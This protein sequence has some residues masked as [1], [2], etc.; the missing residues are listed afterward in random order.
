MNKRLVK[1]NLITSIILQFAT[2][3]SG[4][5]TPKVLLKAFGS[6]TNGLVSSI[7]QFIN[8]ITLLEGGVTSVAIASLYKPIN[9]ND[10]HEISKKI[11]AISHYFRTLSILSALFTIIVGLIYPLLVKTDF[12]NLYIFLLTCVLGGHLLIQYSLSITYKI[13]LRA[14]QKVYY[15][16]LT[17]LIIVVINLAVVIVTVNYFKDILIVKMASLATYLIQPLMYTTYVKRHY[18]IPKISKKEVG[19]LD[20]K[21]DGFGINLAYF[22]HSN[23]DI[24][25]LT[26]L[27]TL[28]N[29]SVY[30][31]H[32]LI[33]SSLKA[34][35][36]TMSSSFSPTMGTII[37]KDDNVKTNKVFDRYELIIVLLSFILFTCGA[38]L[39]TSF[40]DVYT[41]GIYD[42]DYHQPVFGIILM[43][44]EMMYCIR[45]PY[46][47]VTYASGHFRQTAKFAYIEAVTNIVISIILIRFLGLIGVAIGTLIAMFI[48]TI[49]HVLYLRGNILRR[50]ASLFIK[51]FVLFGVPSIAAFITCKSLIVKDISTYRAWIS[52]AIMCFIVTAALN[53]VV[54]FSFYKNELIDIISA[55]KPSKK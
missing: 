9:N 16:S 45:D 21:W 38:E 50:P 54:A 10:M 18:D 39:I 48:R 53:F 5:I 11:S 2:I 3:V 36:V 6:E 12:S 30:S 32:N 23:T 26:F 14:D 40:V 8:Y 22:V 19:T 31:I 42:T 25:L 37:A 20:Q 29:V 33:V 17:Q 43:L 1:L 46:V 52:Q 55:M 28:A 13:F 51:K 27:S 49:L 41:K 34:V 35:V 4:F 24:V 44:A 47:N 15:I 7:N